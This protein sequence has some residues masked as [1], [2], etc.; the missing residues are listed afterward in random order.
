MNFRTQQK[1]AEC[2]KRKG[3]KRDPY[4][5]EQEYEMEL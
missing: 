2:N 1:Y 4:T 5:R 3:E